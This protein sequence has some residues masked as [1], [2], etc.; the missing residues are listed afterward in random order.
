M[1]LKSAFRFLQALWPD[2][3][4]AGKPAT[5]AGLGYVPTLQADDTVI[6]AKALGELLIDDASGE[7]LYDDATGDV[8]YDG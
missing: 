6:W 1:S 3:A 8:L 2:T 7:F 4:D 5:G